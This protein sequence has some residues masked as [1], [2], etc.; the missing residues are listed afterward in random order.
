MTDTKMRDM[1]FT[2]TKNEDGTYDIRNSADHG[3][4]RCNQNRYS[5]KASE[6][7]EAMWDL[8]DIY[9]NIYG[10]GCTFDVC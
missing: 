8:S 7:F 10:V 4:F 9:N 5:V 1:A 3:M 6:L 2:I